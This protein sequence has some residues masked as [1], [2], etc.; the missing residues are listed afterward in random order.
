MAPG[1]FYVTDDQFVDA[2]GEDVAL[3][4][5]NWVSSVSS[6]RVNLGRLVAHGKAMGSLVAL[7]ITQGVG[8]V[9]IDLGRLKVDFAASTSLKWL[10][11]VPGTGFAHVD[12][13]CFAP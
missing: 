4:M 3:A 11:G 9:P 13:I 5:I 8:I 2:W 12:P 1:N 7:D 10:C 6:K